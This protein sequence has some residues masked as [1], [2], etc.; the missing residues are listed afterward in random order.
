MKRLKPVLTTTLMVVLCSSSVRAFAADTP[1]SGPQIYI[2]G[3]AGYGRVNGEDFTNSNGDLT[4]NRVSWKALAGFKFNP[5]V[6]IE[7]Q[8]IDFGASNRSSDQ[9]KASGWTADLVIDA[10]ITPIVTPYGKVGALMWK[11]DSRFNGIGRDNNGTSL[12]YG[13]GVR[14]KLTE[15]LDL[16][17][18]YERFKMDSTHVDS[19]SAILQFNF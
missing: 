15:N 2:G 11:T 12:A 5:V 6:S 1:S 18:E 17:T 14:F 8:Y 16:R 4:K 19:A 7:G 3:G 9:V 10:P 13:A